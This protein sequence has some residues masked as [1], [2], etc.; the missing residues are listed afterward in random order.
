MAICS[1]EDCDIYANRVGH[2]WCEKHYGRFRRHGSTGL[3]PNHKDCKL[4]HTGGYLLVYAPKHPLAKSAR[5]YEHRFVY[6]NEHGEGP[7]DC[8]HCGVEVRWDN[9]HID[10]LDDNKKNNSLSNLVSSCPSCNKTRGRTKMIK[11]KRAQGVNITFN[12]ETKHIS[13]WC[14][15]IG[16]SRPAL[17]TRLKNWPLEKAMTSVKGNTGPK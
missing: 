14:K 11:T 4:E 13:E 3:A 16:I 2:G 15:I 5:L 17:C 12:G 7:F 1:V 9:L 10:H 8:F 6:Y